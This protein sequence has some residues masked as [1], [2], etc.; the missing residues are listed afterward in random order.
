MLAHGA[1]INGANVVHAAAF[2][3]SSCGARD[4]EGYVATLTFL[5]ENSADMNNRRFRDNLSPLGLA[6]ESGNTGAID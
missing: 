1:D 3:G 5:C 6:L 2:G 4:S